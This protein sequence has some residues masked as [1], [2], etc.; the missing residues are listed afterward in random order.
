M[1]HTKT[2][3]HCSLSASEETN[4]RKHSLWAKCRV[5]NVKAGGTYNYYRAVKKQTD[6]LECLKKLKFCPPVSY[7]KTHK[8]KNVSVRKR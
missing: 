3:I 2:I 6:I 1:L 8:S 4:T 7:T 5:L